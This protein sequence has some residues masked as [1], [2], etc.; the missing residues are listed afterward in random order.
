MDVST[1]F[2]IGHASLHD[3][4]SSHSKS[5][6]YTPT[7]RS[8]LPHSSAMTVD[9]SSSSLFPQYHTSVGTQLGK[10]NAGNKTNIGHRSSFNV[11]I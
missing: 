9:E 3:I 8:T 10:T 7:R 4:H 5:A 2:T 6:F 1:H 11:C